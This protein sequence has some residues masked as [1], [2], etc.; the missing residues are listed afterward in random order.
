MSKT[1][2]LVQNLAKQY[3]LPFDHSLTQLI[4]Q[5]SLSLSIIQDQ[6]FPMTHSL[7]ITHEYKQQFLYEIHQISLIKD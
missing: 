3:N 2:E 6:N 1:E 4:L 5:I 7:N